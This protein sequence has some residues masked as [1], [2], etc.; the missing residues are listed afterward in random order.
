CLARFE[1]DWG[2]RPTFDHRNEVPIGTDFNQLSFRDFKRYWRENHPSNH[3]SATE[4][5]KGRAEP[6][7]LGDIRQI[8]GSVDAGGVLLLIDKPDEHVHIVVPVV[9]VEDQW[10]IADGQ[11]IWREN[12]VE[13]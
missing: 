5:A 9:R 1:D 7:D 2:G 8:A 4:R 12:K 11:M 3:A 6:P 10:W 13:R